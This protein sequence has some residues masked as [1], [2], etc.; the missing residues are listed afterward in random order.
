MQQDSEQQPTARELYDCVCIKH[1][2]GRIHKVSHTA[3]QQHLASAGSEEE[4]HRIHA[5]RLLGERITS[6]P[7]LAE[8]AFPL[9]SSSSV[10]RSVRR[11]EARRGLATRARED[12][13]PT[14]YV[15]RRK[16]ARLKQPIRT[17]QNEADSGQQVSS[18]SYLRGLV[19]HQ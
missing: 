19:L 13:D 7:P 17:N 3:W 10:P 16:R 11:A 12:R 15:G 14:E 8:H 4:R 2:Y 6:L 5:A 9:D 18:F 1:G